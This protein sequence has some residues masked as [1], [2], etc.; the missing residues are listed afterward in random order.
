MGYLSPLIDGYYRS[1][2]KKDY[3]DQKSGE[4]RAMEEIPQGV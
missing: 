4:I 2:N 3:R 1:G